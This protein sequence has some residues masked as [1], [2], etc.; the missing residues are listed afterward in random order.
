MLEYWWLLVL[1]PLL[2]VAVGIF[3]VRRGTGERAKSIYALA[4]TYVLI[5]LLPFMDPPFNYATAVFLVLNL[6][7]LFGRV[8]EREDADR[9]E[10][11]VIRTPSDPSIS[12][13]TP[14]VS[15]TPSHRR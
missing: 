7:L 15:R 13:F 11:W 5:L 12:G 10:G 4:P 6:L 2:Y 8:F 9:A 1:V 14:G 3:L